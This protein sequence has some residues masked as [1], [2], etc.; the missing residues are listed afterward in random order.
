MFLNTGT[1]LVV[2]IV[3]GGLAERFHET[4]QQLEKH[5]KDFQDLPAFKDL[6]FLS[7]GTGLVALDHD[8]R[9]TAFNRAAEEIAGVPTAEAIGRAWPDVFGSAVPLQTIE[10]GIA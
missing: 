6:I 4:R 5:R 2:A 10:S 8:F 1:F 9:I 7:V 3:A